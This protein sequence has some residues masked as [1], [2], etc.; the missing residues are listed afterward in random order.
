[1][2]AARSASSALGSDGTTAMKPPRRR[3]SSVGIVTGACV[4]Q[5]R[6]RRRVQ[7]LRIGAVR[8]MEGRFHRP[9]EAVF[10][11]RSG[12]QLGRGGQARDIR[13]VYRYTGL[14]VPAEP[15]RARRVELALRNHIYAVA[16]VSAQPV[17]LH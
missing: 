3:T 8:K 1:M 16:P 11:R 6:L 10:A 17:T 14:G 15:C 5:K 13:M 2:A 12:Q 7:T 4:L 9:V